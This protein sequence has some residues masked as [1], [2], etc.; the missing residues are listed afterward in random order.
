MT[1]SWSSLSVVPLLTV[2][3]H[4]AIASALISGERGGITQATNDAYRGSGLFHIL[5]IS[6]L[7]MVIMAGAVFYSVRL[8][9]AAIP[10]IALR[11]PIKKWAAVAGIIGALGYLY[12]VR[13]PRILERRLALERI[14]D[15]RAIDRQRRDAR[16]GTSAEELERRAAARRDVAHL[17]V[18]PDNAALLLQQPNVDGFLVG[19]AS[20]VADDFLRIVRYRTGNS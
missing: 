20:L 5:S 11:Y 2:S 6:G 7:H 18:K 12:M 15:P 17:G 13:L 4:G 3:G 9:L 16:Q 1:T 10:S 19:G 14:E 8:L